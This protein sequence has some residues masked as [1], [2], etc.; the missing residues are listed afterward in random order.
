MSNYMH[1]G[2]NRWNSTYKRVYMGGG[3]GGGEEIEKSY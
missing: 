1:V 2:T 3:G